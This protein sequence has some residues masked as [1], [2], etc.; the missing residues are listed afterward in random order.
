MTMIPTLRRVMVEDF[1][2]VT[3]PVGQ[4]KM[5]IHLLKLIDLTENILKLF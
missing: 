2:I 1:E 3:E 4:L 5:M